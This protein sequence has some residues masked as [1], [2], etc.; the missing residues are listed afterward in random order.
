MNGTKI[1]QESLILTKKG[2]EPAL[3]GGSALGI[4][5]IEMITQSFISLGCLDYKVDNGHYDNQ[6]Y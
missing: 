2:S 3:G 5:N 4:T 6:L 1:W